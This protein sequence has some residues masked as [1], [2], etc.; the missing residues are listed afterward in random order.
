MGKPISSLL[1]TL[2]ILI[3][4]AIGVIAQQ[5]DN[6]DFTSVEIIE[7]DQDPVV[8]P[9]DWRLSIGEGH[10]PV[11]IVDQEIKGIASFTIN[12]NERSLSFQNGI[13][14][15]ELEIDVKG[16]LVSVFHENSIGE[17][18][19]KIYH[20]SRNKDG[21]LRIRH[22]PLWL[23]IVPPL[24][25]ILFALIFKEVII[26][27]FAGIWFGA[28][29]AGG[30]RIEAPFYILLS[31][32]DVIKKYMIGALTDSGHLAVI[33]FS[34][35]IGGMVALISKNGGMAGV[36]ERL[37]K[38]A[39]NRVSTQLVT[40]LMGIAIFFDDYANT[41]I[42]GNTVR[43]V[44]DKFRISREKLAYIVDSTAA[45]VSAIALITTW[46]GAEL[47]FIDSGI[48][49]IEGFADNSTPYSL[50]L[51][52][53][54]YSFYPVLTL[55]FVYMLI[56]SERDYGPM[57]KA[58]HRALVK[59]QVVSD[60][61]LNSDEGNMEDLTPVKDAPRKWLH[62]GVPVI[63]VIFTTIFG[64]VYTG[65]E[66]SYTGLLDKGIQLDYSWMLIWSQLPELMGSGDAGFFQRVGVLVG[67]A[68]SYEALIWA[69]FTGV[70]SAIII[71]VYN[72]ILSVKDSIFWMTAGFKTMLPAL[73]ILVLAWSLAIVTD[74]LH[75]ADFI[76]MAIG[77]GLSPFA[78]PALI[79]VLAALISFSTGSSWSTMAILYPIAL[80]TTWALCELA[81]LPYDQSLEIMLNVIATVLAAS[82]LGDHCS[83]ISDTTILSSLASDCNH[84]DH[85]RT[86]LPYALTVG[87][88]SFLCTSTINILGGSWLL[89][90][91][92]GAVSVVILWLVL[93]FIGKPVND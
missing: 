76:T 29:V 56:R 46:I 21:T 40:W 48:R 37:S 77:G 75:T 79:F 90:F 50:F 60:D 24:M 4:S 78:M 39:N 57:W 66:S 81:G 27:L 3:V 67:N 25:A 63:L 36:V 20:L 10:I 41:L 65:F 47:G 51:S 58:E 87:S 72:R 93:R 49:Y 54:K 59:G 84:I 28:F 52:S 62:A 1:I 80:P 70:V 88:V 34:L 31:F 82:V 23:S 38:F 83:P 30:L 86:Q 44:T 91:V 69:S 6:T 71:S 74:E 68:D 92:Y 12:G 5:A 19:L 32:F 85:V 42:V 53:L 13:S 7:Y 45:P 35:L 9:K 89:T 17:H 26:S 2:F 18:T 33:I 43:S 61:Q 22:I 73:I 64:L 55:I 14:E 11:I 15:L 16:T 8:F